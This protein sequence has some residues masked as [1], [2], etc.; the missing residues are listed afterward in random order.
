MFKAKYV[1]SA[2]AI[3]IFP[4]NITNKKKGELLYGDHSN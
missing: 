3:I 4:V 1:Q 2:L